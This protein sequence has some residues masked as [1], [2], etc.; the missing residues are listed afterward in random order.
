[1][2]LLDINGRRVSWSREDWMLHCPGNARTG[3]W[4]WMGWWGNTLIE[5]G[6]GE[7]GQGVLEGKPEKGITFEM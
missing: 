3:E 5:A 2:A 1:M 4:E 6:K 7:M